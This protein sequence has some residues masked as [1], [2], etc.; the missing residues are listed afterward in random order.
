MGSL[1]EGTVYHLIGKGDRPR[2]RC[3]WIQVGPLP[4]HLGNRFGIASPNQGLI[5]HRRHLGTGGFSI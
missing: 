4:G 1:P 2:G 5:E 3:D